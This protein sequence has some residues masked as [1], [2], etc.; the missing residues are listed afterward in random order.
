MSSRAGAKTGSG[1]GLHEAHTLHGKPPYARLPVFL[2]PLSFQPLLTLRTMQHCAETVPFVMAWERK[3]R[4][5]GLDVCMCES[6]VSHGQAGCSSSS[7][8]H[9]AH[10]E[11]S[12]S[13]RLE[14]GQPTAECPTLNCT[15][16][17]RME[18]G[19]GLVPRGPWR[20]FLVAVGAGSGP[21]MS[22]QSQIICGD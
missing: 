19:E 22:P 10:R 21:W 1:L 14:A 3:K 18:K 11:H 12:L 15:A 13:P 8:L 20:T 5:A 4:E 2:I 6:P 17:E 16:R 7:G 9:R